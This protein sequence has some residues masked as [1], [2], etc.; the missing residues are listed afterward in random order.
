MINSS[1]GETGFYF[2]P[3]KDT[4]GSTKLDPRQLRK[5]EIDV[6]KGDEYAYLECG[7]PINEADLIARERMSPEEIRALLRRQR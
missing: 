2:A 6:E 3:P 4:D 7:D 1:F 5:T